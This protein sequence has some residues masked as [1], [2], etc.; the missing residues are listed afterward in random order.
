[1]PSAGNNGFKAEKNFYDYKTGQLLTET[2]DIFM[3]LLEGGEEDLIMA[4]TY[5]RLSHKAIVT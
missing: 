4:R 2:M 1:M 3:P 5:E